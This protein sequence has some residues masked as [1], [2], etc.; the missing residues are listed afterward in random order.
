[1]KILY[2]SIFEMPHIGG[3]GEINYA[4]GRIGSEVV[5]I[6]ETAKKAMQEARTMSLIS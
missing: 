5:R 2:V 4:D 3:K 1:M 6:I